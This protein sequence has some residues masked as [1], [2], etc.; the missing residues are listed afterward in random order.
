[1]EIIRETPLCELAYKYGTD[2][3]PSLKHNYTPYYYQRFRD[4]KEDVLVMF[5]MGIGYY[6]G[7]ENS[8][9][10]Y[11]PGLD[12]W[13]QKGASLKMWRD[14]FPNAEVIGADIQ[15]ATQFTDTR[16]RT[17]LCDQTNPE[18]VK[19]MLKDIGKRI[20]IFIDDGS[21]AK[22]DQVKLA[23]AALPFLRDDVVYIIEDVY[24]PNYVVSHLKDYK[25]HVP[26]LQ[27]DSLSEKEYRDDT[28]VVVEKC[29]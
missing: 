29:L 3:C 4:I 6:K 7:I 1:M 26:D 17:L 20:D 11:D 21:H 14:F 22:R 24:S 9:L 2:K 15:P 5:E 10:K 12:R 18:D 23:N 8:D 16:I 19:N 25:C 28:I 13:Y 27:A